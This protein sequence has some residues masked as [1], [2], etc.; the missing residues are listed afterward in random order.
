[1]KI[2]PLALFCLVLGVR[3]VDTVQG[4]TLKP[5]PLLLAA[6]VGIVRP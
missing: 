4:L 3:T 1:M 5:R 6:V 2:R